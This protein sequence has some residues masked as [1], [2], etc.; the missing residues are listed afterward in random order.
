M[1]KCKCKRN[2]KWEDLCDA[3][4]KEVVAKEKMVAD[5]LWLL[6]WLN[7]GKIDNFRHSLKCMQ[8]RYNR[9]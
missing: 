3:C 2:C 5:T 8:A 7:I 9:V 1:V 4:K 6:K